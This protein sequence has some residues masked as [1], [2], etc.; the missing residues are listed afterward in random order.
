MRKLTSLP[1]VVVV[2]FC[3]S[4]GARAQAPAAPEPVLDHV[5]PDVVGA[6]VIHD[7]GKAGANA[8]EFLLAVSP[9]DEIILPLP[10]VE[11]I[12]ARFGIG[13]GFNPAGGFAAFLLNP[14]PYGLEL[15]EALAGKRKDGSKIT[16]D[17][18]PLVILIPGK[19]PARMFAF[20]K[21]TAADGVVQFK[22]EDGRARYCMQV[23]GYVALGANLKA[24]KAVAAGTKS[25]ATAL[26]KADRDF[27]DSHDAAVW[28][29]T[30][31]LAP[32]VAARAVTARGPK[33][34]GGGGMLAA[35]MALKGDPG[36]QWNA[37][38]GQMRSAIAGLRFAKEGLYI[39]AGGAFRPD[40][41]M[42]KALAAYTP[43][44]PKLL[45][46][47]PGPPYTVALGMLNAP[48]PS[49][50]MLSERIDR[51]LAGPPYKD[52]PADARDKLRKAAVALDEQ[53]KAVQLY[54]GPISSPMR[55]AYVVRCESSAK[56]RGQFAEI[57]SVAVQ[58]AE[59]GTDKR[60]E[61][62]TLKYEPNA[63]KVAGREADVFT[64]TPTKAGEAQRK[65]AEAVLGAEALRLVVVQAGEDVLLIAQ[66][67]DAEA[68]VQALAVAEKASG[69][70]AD[71]PNVAKV[72][73]LLPAKRTAVG[74]VD[75]RR[76]QAVIKAV[77]VAGGGK[78]VDVE[79]NS[80]VPFAG[81]VSLAGTSI[82]LTA[83]LPTETLREVMKVV[84]ALLSARAA[85][86]K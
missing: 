83:I 47:L 85:E 3:F 22:G 20:R 55:L 34:K 32:V 72:L 37:L 43:A 84:S 59:A 80:D 31:Q 35:L 74:V 49:K 77:R 71:D 26:S 54:F 58:A 64:M 66:D 69:G 70:I 8:D 39:E 50:K 41:E 63:A 46:R 12:K 40:S 23:G 65:R 56:A 61:G 24:V 52:L 27:I 19:D 76:L 14:K 73:A 6:V 68:I 25:I 29:D 28:V 86:I 51:A 2:A 13:E 78:P 9:P 18:V 5:P 53:V 67:R 60:L 75:A 62:V 36:V 11:L 42:G 10:V 82:R 21:P 45:D 15:G 44:A 1:A 57:M 17:M 79:I 48:T 38:L 81:A 4:A 33:A 30:A 7:V 16:S